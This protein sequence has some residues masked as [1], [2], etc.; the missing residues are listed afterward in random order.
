MDETGIISG[1]VVAFQNIQERLNQE[2]QLRRSEEF[3]QKILEGSSIGTWMNDLVSGEVFW[4]SRT[5]EIFSLESDE[6]ASLERG[7]SLIH[8]EDRM[9]AQKA[10][11]DAISPKSNGGYEEE[12][13][14]I[15]PD[16]QV[17]WISTRGNVI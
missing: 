17:R 10:Y 6:P 15:R 7:L 1:T 16:G 3:R 13:R 4:D 5:R 2:E 9:H 11:E 12:K 8:P 14:I